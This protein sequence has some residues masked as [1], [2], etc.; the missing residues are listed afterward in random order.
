MIRNSL[1]R[2]TRMPMRRLA[3]GGAILCF[4]SITTPDAPAE[5][6]AHV[7]LAAFQSTIGLARRLGEI[8]P[9]SALVRRHEQG[10]STA[11]MVAVT[12]DDA[13]AALLSGL[14]E[15]VSREGIPIS[16]FVVTQAAQAGATYWWDRIDD[17]FPRVAAARWRAFEAACGLP[18]EYRQRQPAALGPLRPL[19][20]WVLAAYAGRWPSHLEPA[21]LSLEYESG[22]RTRHRSMTFAEIAELAALPSVEVGVHTVTHP[23]LPL[24]SDPDLTQEIAAGYA[25]LRSR[26]ASV[27]PILAVPFGLYDER[28]LR[29]ARAAG[30]TAC[31][32]VAG[33]NLDGEAHRY[34]LPRYCVTRHD[35]PARLALC[36]VGLPDRVRRWRGRPLAPYPALPSPTS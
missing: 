11:G 18:E 10:R 15:F 28:T 22:L 29:A 2:V 20:Q 34:V 24:L 19:R 13:Y 33:A 26:L 25:E 5:G 8:V 27:L 23:V 3:S 9:L 21:L 7:S 35:T 30:L 6:T 31:L 32:S 12:F 4:H 16:V 1:N 36:L 14:K 17:L